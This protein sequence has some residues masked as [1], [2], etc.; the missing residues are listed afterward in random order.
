MLR[1]GAQKL[2]IFIKTVFSIHP[3]ADLS[4]RR[5]TG[6]RKDEAAQREEG[7]LGCEAKSWETRSNFGGEVL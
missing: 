5:I 7:C 6:E 2:V 1:G 4:Y 3:S